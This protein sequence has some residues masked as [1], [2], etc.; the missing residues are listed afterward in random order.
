M[1]TKDKILDL[2]DNYIHNI[3][4]TQIDFL[5]DLSNIWATI[6]PAPPQSI[7]YINSLLYIKDVNTIFTDTILNLK[8]IELK[9]K[10]SKNA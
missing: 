2:I 4:A 9:M 3:I 8:K 6:S 1:E 10:E 5:S 7:S